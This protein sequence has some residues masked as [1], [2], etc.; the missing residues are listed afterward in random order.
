M[1][2]PRNIFPLIVNTALGFQ[3]ELKI[4]GNDYPS[5]DGTAVRDYIHVGI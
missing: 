4:Y 2:I 5:K 1:N 3:K